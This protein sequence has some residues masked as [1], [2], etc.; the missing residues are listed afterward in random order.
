MSFG[1]QSPDLTV[2]TR[3]CTAMHH[4]GPDDQGVYANHSVA[5]GQRRLSIIDLTTGRQ[6]LSNEDGSVWVTFNGEIYNFAAL[7]VTLEQHGHRFR[8]TSDTEVI[9]HAYE[10]YGSACVEH[11]R[12]MFAF[13]VWDANERVLFLARDRVGKKPLF[14]TLVE[15][16]FVFASEL[17]ALLQHPA[18]PRQ[19]D[20][21]ALDEYLTYGYIPAPKTIFQRIY[22]LPPAHFLRVPLASPANRLEP[23]RYW[24]LDYLPKLTLSEPDTIE[25][26]QELLTEAVRLRLVADVP[27][28]ALLSGGIDSSIIVA[29][30]SGFC[31]QPVKTFSIGFDESE[32]NELPYARQVAQRYQTDHHELVVRPQAL[33]VLPTLVRHY[34]EPFG[35]SSA[36]PSYYVAQLTRQHVTVAL[37]GDGGDESFAGYERYLGNELATLYQRMPLFLQRGVLEPL[38]AL[39]PSSFSR[40]HRLSQLK[41]FVQLAGRPQSER[42]TRWVS[43]FT[44]QQK[45][46]L[47]TPALQQELNGYKSVAWL[48]QQLDTAAANGLAPLDTLLAV[49][50]A[51]YLPNDLLVKIDI[52]TMANSLEARSPLLDHKVMEFAAT[53]PTQAKLRGRTLKYLLKKLGQRYLPADLLTRRKTGFGVPVGSWMRHELRP[54]IQDMLLSSNARINTYL[55]PEAVA[56]LVH[57]HLVCRNDHSQ[58]LWSILWLELWHREFLN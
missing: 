15:N 22:K 23:Q 43:S 45:E 17:Q 1:E 53:L 18:I 38:A 6:P 3:I 32:F 11:F 14:Y 54:L 7:R 24:Q 55:R 35:D 30:M 12:G 16:V 19:L 39:L 41:R 27:L 34:G 42:Y 44:P 48:E 49:D 29:L 26:F 37:N 8:T 13:A 2:L 25:A 50:V 47:Y 10:Q 46:L 4:R 28:G 20:W 57:E 5:L 9:V 33:D 52:A 21:I 36:I 58:Q 31:S 51:T 40:R 56:Q